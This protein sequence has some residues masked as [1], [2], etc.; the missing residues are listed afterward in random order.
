MT[1]KLDSMPACPNVS[2]SAPHSRMTSLELA[3]RPKAD[4]RP[5][6]AIL[7]PAQWLLVTPRHDSAFEGFCQSPPMGANRV[8]RGSRRKSQLAATPDVAASPTLAGPDGACRSEGILAYVSFNS[9]PRLA[10]LAPTLSEPAAAAAA[11]PAP[12]GRVPPLLVRV[13]SSLRRLLRL[14]RPTPAAAAAY[15]ASPQESV[16]SAS[17]SAKRRKSFGPMAAGSPAPSVADNVHGQQ[18]QFAPGSS[19]F[20]PIVGTFLPTIEEPGPS[21]DAQGRNAFF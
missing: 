7:S 12:R 15:V 5:S 11:A 6:C 3:S 8:R 2:G 17:A 9:N 16:E 19:P 1:S 4:Q 20:A 13:K 10:R 21:P 14:F 18:V